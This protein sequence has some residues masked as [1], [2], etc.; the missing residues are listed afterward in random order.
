M[1]NYFERTLCCKINYQTIKSIAMKKTIILT[2]ISALF[3]VLNMQAQAPA[4]F[5]KG[6]VTLADGSTISGYVKDNI[7]KNASVTFLDN[8]GSNKQQY[9]GIQVNAAVVD[10]T[11]Y[12]C[13]KGDFFK[14]ICTGKICFLQKA[15]NA[16]GKTIYNGA[17][18]I[19]LPGTEG[20][21][22]DYFSYT[23]N[24]LTL[25]TKK[26]VDAFIS[27]QLNSNAKAAEKAKAV[28]GD[29]AALAEAIAI[30]NSDNK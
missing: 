13:M 6:N 10:G 28:N 23:N 4:G 29:I 3:T 12:S 17:E 21:I 8:N 2:A 20:K 27:T 26:T 19:I 7:K 25:I 5:V 16:S 14:T 24:E 11:N 30:Y 22:G 18:A 9:D 15:S 1:N